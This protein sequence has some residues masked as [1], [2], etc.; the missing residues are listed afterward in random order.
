M[1]FAKGARRA[2]CVDT[3]CWLNAIFGNYSVTRVNYSTRAT[4]FGDSSYIEKNGEWTRVTFFTEWLDSIRVTINDLRL[5]SESFLQNLWASD[6]QT[7][8]VCT[9]RNEHFFSSVMFKIGANFLFW[10]SRHALLYFKDQL[11]PTYTEADLRLLSLRGQQGT[12]PWQLIV[13]SCTICIWC[14]FKTEPFKTDHS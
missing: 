11:S 2:Q 10:L 5:E 3:L 6:E 4:I 1:L 7:Q 8:F 13:V 12:I 9:Q 14:P